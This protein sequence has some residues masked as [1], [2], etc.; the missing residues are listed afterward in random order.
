MLIS[1]AMLDCHGGLEA[2]DGGLEAVLSVRKTM[3]SDYNV[4]NGL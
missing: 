1:G 2:V 3:T 4:C